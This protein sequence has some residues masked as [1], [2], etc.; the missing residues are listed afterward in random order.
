MWSAITI[1]WSVADLFVIKKSGKNCQRIDNNLDALGEL[2]QV[3]TVQ[4][5]Y[6]I[7]VVSQIL[8]IFVINAAYLCA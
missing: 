1:L 6:S 7:W 2:E 8:M 5:Y 3:F 4:L